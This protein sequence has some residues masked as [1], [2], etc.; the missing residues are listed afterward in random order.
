MAYDEQHNYLQLGAAH[1]WWFLSRAQTMG[2]LVGGFVGVIIGMQLGPFAMLVSTLLG[3][4]VG[5]II[6]TQVGGL[7]LAR[8]GWHIAHYLVRRVAQVEPAG[9]ADQDVS[10]AVPA[11]YC[12]V[13]RGEQMEWSYWRPGNVEGDA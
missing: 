3:G 6:G 4:F 11:F 1:G 2:L 7:T 8:Q 10:A 9:P 5:V 13:M 12:E